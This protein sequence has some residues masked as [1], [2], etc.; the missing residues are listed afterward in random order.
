[1]AQIGKQFNRIDADKSGDL[2]WEEVKAAVKIEVTNSAITAKREQE[3]ERMRATDKDRGKEPTAAGSS[4]AKQSAGASPTGAVSGH[5][6]G[7]DGASDV[8]DMAAYL[9]EW[10]RE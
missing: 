8:N 10:T 4:P 7:V 2:T 3:K 9:R 5:A 6:G 1:M